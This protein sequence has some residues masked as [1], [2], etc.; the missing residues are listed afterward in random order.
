VV[1]RIDAVGVAALSKGKK[2]HWLQITEEDA[3][4]NTPSFVFRSH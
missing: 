1:A 2:I 4:V 3:E